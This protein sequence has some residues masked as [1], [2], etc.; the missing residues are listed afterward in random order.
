[1]IIQNIQ[2]ASL[3]R[4]NYLLSQEASEESFNLCTQELNSL[5][6]LLGLEFDKGIYSLIFDQLDFKDPKLFMNSNQI[7]YHYFLKIF[8][9]DLKHN[10][11]VNFL[12][13]ILMR[14]RNNNN[15]NEIFDTLNKLMKL[16]DEDQ[17]KILLAFI[18]SKNPNYFNDAMTLMCNKIKKMENE[19]LVHKI[20]PKLSQDILSILSN[21][22]N[23]K[24]S[25]DIN[26]HEFNT[27]AK[28]KEQI[29]QD[30]KSESMK[31]LSILDSDIAN[32]NNDLIPLEK[33]YEDLGPT[34]FNSCKTII[35]KSPLID[36]SLDAKKIAGLIISILRNTPFNE[37]KEKE[38]R[39]MN[40]SF[41]KSL[42][43]E[44]R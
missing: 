14:T 42:D 18:L 29:S 31:L 22:K 19:N 15:A 21:K 20:D 13:E 6:K 43:L 26:L 1:M 27:L 24:I 11:F 9:K 34:L 32:I 16:T 28:N 7:R 3:I 8:P 41:L 39:I 37:E 4:A 36:N 44:E 30:N 12:A 25:Q 5:S 33:L 2:E 17:F 38:I 40:K 23:V 10:K 35:P